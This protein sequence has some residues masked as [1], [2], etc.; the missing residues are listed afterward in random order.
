MPRLIYAILGL[1]LIYATITI[2]PWYILVIVLIFILDILQ[3]VEEVAKC[4]KEYRW[5]MNDGPNSMNKVK[6]F[7]NKETGEINTCVWVG[8]TAGYYKSNGKKYDRTM[9]EI[10]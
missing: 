4:E 2:S 7:R 5:Q 8:G 6:F 10:L 1:V 9:K 3:G